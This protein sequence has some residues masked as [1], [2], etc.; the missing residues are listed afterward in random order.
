[1][2][3]L[4]VGGSPVPTTSPALINV[5]RAVDQGEES[6]ESDPLFLVTPGVCFAHQGWSRHQA[7]S[8]STR[9][10]EPQTA[11]PSPQNPI[12]SPETPSA[13]T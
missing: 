4:L 11:H 2:R 10:L 6:R 12:P 1:M 3:R 5:S 13:K 7:L 9:N 8:P